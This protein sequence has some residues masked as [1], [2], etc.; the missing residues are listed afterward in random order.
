MPGAKL[1]LSLTV[2]ALGKL[3]LSQQ[4]RNQVIDRDSK[5]GPNKVKGGTTV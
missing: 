5:N 4:T 1:R 3:K 2:G